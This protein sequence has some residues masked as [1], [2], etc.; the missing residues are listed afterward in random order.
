MSP[1]NWL[2]EKI[3]ASQH[4]QTYADKINGLVIKK[5]EG[6]VLTLINTLQLID[7]VSCSYLGLDLDARVIAA[8]NSH[9]HQCGVT[10]PAARTRIQVDSFDVLEGLLSNIFNQLP[11]VIFQN[12]HVGH[13]GILPLLGSG[14]MPSFP[15]ADNGFV[16]LFDHVA[17]SS[18]QIN[19]A[20]MTQFGDVVMC[21]LATAESIAQAFQEAHR[22][23]KTPVAICDSIGSMGGINPVEALYHCAETYQGYVYIDDAHGT[24]IIGKNGCG[25]VLHALR[26]KD[27]ARFILTLSLSKAFGSVGGVA[28]LPTAEDVAM[29]KHYAPTYVFSGPLPLSAVDS[30]IAAAHIHLSPEMASLQQ[31][32]WE[33][34]AYFDSKLSAPILNQHTLTPIRGIVVGDENLAIDYAL[35]L[36]EY[37]FAVTTAMYPTVPKSQSLLRL[38]LSAQHTK[39]QLDRLCS[40][41]NF[42]FGSK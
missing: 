14:E 12:L 36:R 37:G 13:L 39:E 32:L 18:L 3:K 4:Y 15:A 8:A 1:R 10:F 31:A 23:H 29:I 24:S 7:F 25:H 33:N 16:F 41:I 42:L 9:I 5:R 22:Q 40:C 28:V 20:L 26:G 35:H 11:C 30:A 19:R 34:V 6:R 17:H 21:S 27:T 2:K 38:A